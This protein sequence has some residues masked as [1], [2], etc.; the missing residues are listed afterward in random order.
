MRLKLRAGALLARLLARARNPAARDV[1]LTTFVT[2][3]GMALSIG[4]SPIVAHAIGADGRGAIAGSF[5]MVQ[6][7]SWAG[8]LSLP[9]VLARD[10]TDDV[11]LSRSGIAVLTILGFINM[12]IILVMADTLSNGDERIALGMRIASFLLPLSGIS[13]VGIELCLARGRIILFNLPRLGYAVAPSL[14]IIILALVGALDL[15]SAYLATLGGQ[16]ITLAVGIA[17]GI[18]AIR[19]PVSRRV[20]WKQAGHL[21]AGNALDSVSSQLG[22]VLLA[23]LSTASQVGIYSIAVMLASASGALAQA[24]MQSSYSRFIRQATVA[25][26]SDSPELREASWIGITSTMF[27]G[28]LVVIGVHFW[29]ATLFGD[30]FTGLAFV[31]AFTLIAQVLS[32]QWQLRVMHDTA[33][34]EVGAI[35]AS[36]LVGAL[37]LAVIATILGA[38]G[39]L[40][41]A[42]MAV[43][44]ASGTAT[45]I[46]S[47][48]FLKHGP[49]SASRRERIEN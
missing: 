21:W 28:V 42:S 6:T 24:I 35:A 10:A 41:A 11:S 38:T 33:H 34:R 49:W 5:A 30:T 1:M 9:R 14:T 20:P 18:G 40:N 12:A 23:A 32:D 46:A 4:S 25:P 29:G 22:Q 27:V 13:Q 36:S 47:R 44:V 45:K 37:V 26:R 17:L 39:S 8:F 3:S 48:L 43:A 16:F 7:L 19:S 31:A 15:R 2:Y